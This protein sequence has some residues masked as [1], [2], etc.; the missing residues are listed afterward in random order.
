MAPYTLAGNSVRAARA[1]YYRA[2]VFETLH[3]PFCLAL[4][5]LAIHRAAIGR[6]D[7]AI[8]HVVVNL[9]INLYPM[10][11]HRRT[12]VRIVELLRAAA[13][14]VSRGTEPAS[15]TEPDHARRGT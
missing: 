11:H 10:M 5:S 13:G 4:L 8:Q 12:R 15:E 6:L 2:C 1:F 9:A 14:G 3:M 7:F